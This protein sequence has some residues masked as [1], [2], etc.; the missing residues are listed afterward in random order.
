M[1]ALIR[2]YF[3]PFFMLVVQISAISAVISTAYKVK[4]NERALKA[5]REEPDGQWYR[6]VQERL[7]VG[8]PATEAQ[9]R[10][11]FRNY[12]INE[13]ES[14]G[15]YVEPGPSH[16]VIH[17]HSDGYMATLALARRRNYAMKA[18]VNRFL[19]D[20]DVMD[21]AQSVNENCC[22]RQAE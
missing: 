9:V 18:E 15:L 6:L 1:M 20:M 10:N 3:L 17:I 16:Y 19:H 21:M 8:I 12:S 14:N 11:L 5:F 7:R 4:C 2:P 13:R 22:D